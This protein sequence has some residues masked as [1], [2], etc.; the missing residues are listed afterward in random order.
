MA[1]NN[2]VHRDRTRALSLTGRGSAESWRLITHTWVF[3]RTSIDEPPSPCPRALAGKKK[4]VAHSG[5]AHILRR[6]RKQVSHHT[7]GG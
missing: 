5:T 4:C 7:L 6:V 3:C 1:E 2:T